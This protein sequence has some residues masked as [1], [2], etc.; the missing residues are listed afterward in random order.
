MVA[1]KTAGLGVPAAH[2]GREL[3]W[4]HQVAEEL[5]ALDDIPADLIDQA[6]GNFNILTSVEYDS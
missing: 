6:M 5:T 1:R 4:L 3:G 2:L